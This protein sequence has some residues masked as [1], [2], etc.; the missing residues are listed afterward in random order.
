M[1]NKIKLREYQQDIVTQT[2]KSNKHTLIQVPTGGGKTVISRFIAFDLSY[3]QNKQIL[4]VAPKLVL[5][6]Q[7][8]KAFKDINPQKVHGSEYYNPKHKVL[9]ST[10]QTASRREELQP[11]VIIIDEIHHGYD[12][13]MIEKLIQNKPNTRVIGLSA[14]PYDRKG[15][16]LKGFELI[17]D[18]YDMNYM[19]EHN[20][21]VGLKPYVLVR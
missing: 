12:G 4:F 2:I 21:L 10:L 9:V 3:K 17:L 15:K 1:S 14:T 8:L 16:L 6:E 20:F 11:D 19:I 5:M 7:T 18:K 13:S